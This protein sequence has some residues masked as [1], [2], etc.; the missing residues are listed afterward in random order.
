[1]NTRDFE[2]LIAL[3]EHHHFGKAAEACFVS[4]P[5]LSMQIQ[6]LEASLGV[7]LLERS[8]K[9][10][11]LTDIGIAITERAKQILAQINEIRD[12][13][14][15]SKDPY[16]GRLTIGVI[17]TLG[18]YLLPLILPALSKKFPHLHFY[19]VEEQT[20][21][22][23]QKLKI[24]SLDAAL[25]AHPIE[26]SSF[27]ATDLFAEEFL[28]AV[29]NKHVLAQRKFINACD[30]QQQNLLLLEEGHCMR[31]QTLDL[32]HK[33]NVNEVQNFRATSLETLRQMVATGNDVTLM[34]KLAQQ[35]RDGISYI[36]FNAPR[37]VRQIAC[38]W[39][40]SSVKTI[41]LD[42]MVEQ[43]KI[44]SVKKGLTIPR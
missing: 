22:L 27:S 16:S 30:L 25:M 21:A 3:S 15:L 42:A 5:A 17:P 7:K 28:L 35:A 1:M 23:I 14:K 4:Q 8:N 34:P 11:L 6:R 36:P 39:R 38:Y 12:L 31:G 18:P 43:I 32:C 40:S 41:V 26:E 20:S 33:M 2:Y 29:A 19:L 10:V 9:S 24:G 44:L 13:A 37:P